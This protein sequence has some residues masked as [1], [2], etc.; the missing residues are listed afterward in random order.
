MFIMRA[1]H[2][3]RILD[4][5]RCARRY[6]PENR[7]RNSPHPH[8]RIAVEKNNKEIQIL[9]NNYLNCVTLILQTRYIDTSAKARV[10]IY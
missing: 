7:P 10:V 5:F 9:Q 8:P 3:V 2:A 6:V 4:T 1:T